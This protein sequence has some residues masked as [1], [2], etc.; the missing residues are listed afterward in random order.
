MK[1]R[2]LSIIALLA[3]TLTAQASP[4]IEALSK[5]VADSTTGKDRKDLARW[6]FVAMS[7]HPEMKSIAN[8][9]P[10]ATEDVSRVAGQLFTRV[11]ADACPGEVKAA[12]QVGGP[13]AIRSAFSVLG[14]LAMQEL[15]TDNDVAATMGALDRYLDKQKLEALSR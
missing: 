6:I 8:V 1:T 3:V 2:F 13:A 7:A 4:Q 11:L 12:I 5:C 10:N 14:Q 15:M 9:A